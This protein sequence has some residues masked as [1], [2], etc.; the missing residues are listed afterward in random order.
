MSGLI[1]ISQICKYMYDTCVRI[2]N[3]AKHN[4]DFLYVFLNLY[5]DSTLSPRIQIIIISTG[6]TL[7]GKYMGSGLNYLQPNGITGDKREHTFQAI[8]STLSR[9]ETGFCMRNI[10]VSKHKASLCS[11]A[12]SSENSRQTEDQLQRWKWGQGGFFF[13][14][15]L[16]QA[17]SLAPTPLL[18]PN[19]EQTQLWKMR[20]KLMSKQSCVCQ[21]LATLCHQNHNLSFFFVCLCTN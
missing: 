12:S 6:F 8:L 4:N 11:T 13:S 19:W 10:V 1:T 2:H 16:N 20:D 5:H 15:F 21:L 14:S 3:F 17:S 9:N 18:I 7:H